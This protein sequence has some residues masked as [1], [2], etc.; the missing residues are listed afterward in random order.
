MV[1]PSFSLL[2]LPCA[3]RRPRFRFS[4]SRRP[5]R[6]PNP[7]GIIT[8]AFGQKR[9]ARRCTCREHFP[10]L[11]FCGPF[12]ALILPFAQCGHVSCARRP[13]RSDQLGNHFDHLL[14]LFPSSRA[15]GRVIFARQVRKCYL[16]SLSF[17]PSTSLF[18]I[19]APQLARRRPATCRRPL[20]TYAD[21]F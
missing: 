5:G 12:R 6:V 4:R 16:L 19:S 15:G 8:S 11:T 1:L 18:A 20:H 7:S 10:K 2:H 3:G 9:A 17:S 13:A 21:G 14:M